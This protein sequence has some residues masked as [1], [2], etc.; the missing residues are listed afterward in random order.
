[1]TASLSD[2]WS[3]LG[4][5]TQQQRSCNCNQVTHDKLRVDCDETVK[6]PSPE[7]TVCKKRSPPGVGAG[8]PGSPVVAFRPYRSS[9]AT[10]CSLLGS[11]ASLPKTVRSKGAEFLLQLRGV[12]PSKGLWV[13]LLKL[14]DDGIYLWRGQAWHMCA[15]AKRAA[16]DLASGMRGL[17]ASGVHKRNLVV[18]FCL[19]SPAVSSCSIRS[20]F[21]ENLK[22]WTPPSAKAL[23]VAIRRSTRHSRLEAMAPNKR[24]ACAAENLCSA[25]GTT[26]D[27]AAAEYPG[28]Q[29][30][31]QSLH[32]K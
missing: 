3:R 13:S 26:G 16:T 22:R 24:G 31:V 5:E 28:R 9:D 14:L 10:A 2:C 8:A 12:V 25:S 11:A 21:E 32:L 30:A 6:H 29:R 7:T 17:T 1:M 20:C 18:V 15:A 4:T 23:A 27:L 19:R